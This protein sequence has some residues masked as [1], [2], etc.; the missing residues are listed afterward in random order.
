M[1]SIRCSL[2]ADAE[3]LKSW[4]LLLTSSLFSNAPLWLY[5][6]TDAI[7]VRP[8]CARD[9]LVQS[10]L[11]VRP[12]PQVHQALRSETH[13]RPPSPRHCLLFR[14]SRAPHLFK[15]KRISGEKPLAP[16]KG[17]VVSLVACMVG[18]LPPN[19]TPFSLVCPPFAASHPCPSDTNFAL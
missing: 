16:R 8:V 19:L 7:P 13:T 6:W 9:S 1:Q 3:A 15:M 4:C 10:L 12:P 18:H 11:Y 17:M 14:C 2:L 5:S